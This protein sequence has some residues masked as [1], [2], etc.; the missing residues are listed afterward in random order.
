MDMV[1]LNS[2]GVSP[3]AVE[4]GLQG[5]QGSSQPAAG[6]GSLVPVS[7]VQ[8]AAGPDSPAASLGRMLGKGTLI[9]TV[10]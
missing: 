2:A 4:R 8:D 6:S 9:D 3:G 7:N 10:V 5:V 1:D